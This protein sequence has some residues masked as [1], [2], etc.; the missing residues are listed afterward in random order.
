M[1]VRCRLAPDRSPADFSLGDGSHSSD[2]HILC[3]ANR[4]AP[5]AGVQRPPG[6]GGPSV[7]AGYQA[8][9]LMA[10]YFIMGVVCCPLIFALFF[11]D[12]LRLI[13]LP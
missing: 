8:G 6:C 11:N 4:D 13:H 2:R 7:R 12:F 9:L 3:S 10:T 1:W 5:S